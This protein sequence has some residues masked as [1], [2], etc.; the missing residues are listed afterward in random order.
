MNVL[1]ECVLNKMKNLILE[2]LLKI[3]SYDTNVTH[4]FETLLNTGFQRHSTIEW[5]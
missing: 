4:H 2:K 5:E 1:E 3:D